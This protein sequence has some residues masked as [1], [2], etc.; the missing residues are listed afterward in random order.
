MTS[1]QIQVMQMNVKIQ[2]AAPF[3][4][5]TSFNA[6]TERAYQRN[7]GEFRIKLKYYSFFFYIELAECAVMMLTDKTFQNELPL[8]CSF[9]IITIYMQS[10]HL[11]S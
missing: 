7:G 5:R 8:T 4:I 9:I 6:T 3:V 1:I 2:R 11:F 10:V